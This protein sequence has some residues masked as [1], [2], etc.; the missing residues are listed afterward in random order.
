[1]DAFTTTETYSG[2]LTLEKTSMKVVEFE[3]IGWVVQTW[4]IV[5]DSNEFTFQI[6]PDGGRPT[7]CVFRHQD[8]KPLAGFVDVGTGKLL[9]NGR[10]ADAVLYRWQG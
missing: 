9:E 7:P 8:A 10:E 4:R 6:H 2:D 5:G 3:S 1:M